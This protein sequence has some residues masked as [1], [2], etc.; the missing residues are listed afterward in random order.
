MDEK[1]WLR[2]A[3]AQLR[4]YLHIA[5][6]D[7]LSDAHWAMRLKEIEWIRQREAGE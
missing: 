4:Y 5:D 2:I 1:D 7:A 6:P 3:N